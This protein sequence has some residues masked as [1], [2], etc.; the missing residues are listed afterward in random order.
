M[1]GLEVITVE[2]T[3]E[4]DFTLPD[5]WRL[6][7][8]ESVKESEGLVTLEFPR[9]LVR[10]E[11]LVRGEEMLERARRLG[12]RAGLRCLKA[13]LRLQG[14]LPDYQRGGEVPI[15]AGTVALNDQD[16][17]VVPYAKASGG[18]R[19]LGWILLTGGH[20]PASRL[21]RCSPAKL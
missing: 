19:Y 13:S 2:V 14:Q 4:D 11:N 16:Q 12:Q 7:E 15:F 9:L 3:P 17:R 18:E 8:E 21:V 5:G 20:G 10:G 1:P 6:V